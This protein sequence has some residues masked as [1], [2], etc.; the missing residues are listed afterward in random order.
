MLNTLKI[1]SKYYDVYNLDC[2]KLSDWLHDELKNVVESVQGRLLTLDEDINA[3]ECYKF[4]NPQYAN[5]LKRG[6]ILQARK[7]ILKVF[8]GAGLKDLLNAYSIKQTW[9]KRVIRMLR[10]KEIINVVEYLESNK[11]LCWIY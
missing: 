9:F 8:K 5:S 2:I 3:V 7:D 1:L 6:L 4:S 11:T 10:S